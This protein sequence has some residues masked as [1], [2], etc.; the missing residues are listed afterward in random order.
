M[1]A[2]MNIRPQMGKNVMLTTVR[3]LRTPK[4]RR[5]SKQQTQGRYLHAATVYPTPMIAMR[6]G[7]WGLVR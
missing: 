1:S 7:G 4:K 5:Y 6:V 2:Q 3:Y